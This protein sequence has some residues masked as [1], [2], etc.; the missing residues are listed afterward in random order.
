MDRRAWLGSSA[1]LAVA[2]LAGAPGLML[3]Q[4]RAQ[5]PTAER[6][7]RIGVLHQFPDDSGPPREF[8]QQ[9]AQRGWEVGRNLEFIRRRARPDGSDLD[10]HAKALADLPVDLLY[11]FG[12]PATLAAK[13]ATS[14]IP[15]LFELAADPVANGIVQ[16]LAK[17]GTNCTGTYFGEYDEKLLEVLKRAVPKVRRVL[18]PTSRPSA[19]AQR[20]A[21]RL[22]I[23]ILGFPVRDASDLEAFFVR[24][25]TEKPDGVVVH[26][27]NWMAE[28]SARIAQGML[29]AGAPS[30]AAWTSYSRAGG[31][32]S[33]GPT[34]AGLR[35]RRI[36]RT[37]ALLR[38]ANPAD[39][40]VEQPTHFHLGV[41]LVTARALGV[42][43]P[44]AVLLAADPADVIR[45]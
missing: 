17:P 10:A 7:R 42:Q 38:G 34:Q 12:T 44:N 5:G 33:Y 41:N 19:E 28:Y 13:R 18:Y 6:P 26:N 37:D 24:V 21:E 40:P 15:I 20:M 45:E 1:A 4:A 22:K 23:D 36:E 29:A 35:G 14:S 25:K 3:T 31:L 2:G 16:G 8:L 39:M 11:T 9:L 43:I 30:I 27:V 32:L